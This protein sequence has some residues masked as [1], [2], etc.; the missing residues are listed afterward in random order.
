[1]AHG[2]H[3]AIALSLLLSLDDQRRLFSHYREMREE[4]RL[5]ALQLTAAMV[6]SALA[7]GRDIIIDKVLYNESVLDAYYDTS[8]KHGADVVEII[9]WAPKEIVMSRAHERGYTEGGLLTPERVGFFWEKIN[10][11]KESRSRAI[12]IDTTTLSPEEVLNEAKKSL[13]HYK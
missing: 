7:M 3:E 6:E 11:L 10:T 12:L 8:K 5:A 1:M 2:I 13:F 4:S 9:L